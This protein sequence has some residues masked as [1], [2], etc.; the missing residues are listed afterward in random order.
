VPVGYDVSMP[1]ESD[2]ARLSA[3]LDR[4]RYTIGNTTCNLPDVQQRMAVLAQWGRLA[5]RI[6]S[7]IDGCGGDRFVAAL[8]RIGRVEDFDVAGDDDSAEYWRG[9]KDALFKVREVAL[10]AF[11]PT[12]GG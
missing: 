1:A 3:L 11:N 2:T 10:N 7:E 8:E 6:E 4:I 9:V 5:G 12:Q